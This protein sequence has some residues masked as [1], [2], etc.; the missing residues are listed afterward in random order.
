MKTMTLQNKRLTVTLLSIPL[1]L[2]IPLVAMQFTPEV[3]WTL[4]DFVVMGFLLTGVAVV[5]EFVLRYVKK[6]EYKLG[7][8]LIILLLFLLVWAELAVGIFGTPFAGN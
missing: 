5:I 3:N 8:I 2:L 4:I 1:A 6:K 7:L